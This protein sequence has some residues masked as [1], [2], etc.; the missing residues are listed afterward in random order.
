MREKGVLR[1]ST[2]VQKKF[3]EKLTQESTN[4]LLQ[5]ELKARPGPGSMAR[6]PQK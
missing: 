6:K 3:A 1:S 2:T 4:T 5:M